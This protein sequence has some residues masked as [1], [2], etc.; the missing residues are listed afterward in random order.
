MSTKLLNELLDEVATD[1][2]E[3]IERLRK[4]A[5][6]NLARR[7]TDPCAKAGRHVCGNEHAGDYVPRSRLD[8]MEAEIATLEAKVKSVQE[9]AQTLVAE[10]ATR[11]KEELIKKVK[12][13]RNRLEHSGWVTPAELNRLAELAAGLEKAEINGAPLAQWQDIK[14]A[15]KDGTRVL[16][17]RGKRR[18]CGEWRMNRGEP[19][20]THDAERLYGMKDARDHPPT[21]WIPLPDLPISGG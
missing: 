15:P 12:E 21:H 1:T 6:D 4:S 13:Q 17:L 9:G 20:W 18:I 11:M 2:K 8:A 7:A 10:A 14:S 19:Y 5:A 16:L 3:E